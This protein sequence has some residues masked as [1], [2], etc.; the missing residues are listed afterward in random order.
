MPGLDLL[1]NMEP[2]AWVRLLG[3][4]GLVLIVFVWL[5][6][7][8]FFGKTL[9]YVGLAV[10]VLRAA[11]FDNPLAWRAY[12]ELLDRSDLDFRPR[13]MLRYNLQALQRAPD[14]RY[15]AVGSSQVPA[16]FGRYDMLDDTN[17]LVVFTLPGMSIMEYVLY[18]DA[19]RRYQ[20]E[21]IILYL[22]EFDFGR[23]PHMAQLDE[24]PPRFTELPRLW[25]LL[26][27]VMPVEEFL[28]HFNRHILSGL[29]PEHRHRFVFRGL[30]DKLS[31]KQS[32]LAVPSPTEVADDAAQVEHMQRLNR[33]TNEHSVFHLA[34]LGEFFR[35]AQEAGIEVLVVEGQYHPAAYSAQNLRLNGDVRA[36]VRELMQRYPNT[37]YISRQET[38]EFATGDYRDG[39]HVHKAP[40][41]EFT[42]QL[43]LQLGESLAPGITEAP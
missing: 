29:F 31:F 2:W 27:D 21:T 23:A 33:L 30:W 24:A 35:R 19:I 40:G 8:R 34:F 26:S 5:R 15:L 41:L 28:P 1:M 37:R 20:P 42:K 22:S 39:Y 38:Q 4:V 25:E 10:L 12:Q 18:W 14:V 7:R 13:A 16:V 17:Q 32:A 3:T 36:S 11:L 9:V 6:P 43:M